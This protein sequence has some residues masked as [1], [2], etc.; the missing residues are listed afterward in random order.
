MSG[1]AI[2]TERQLLNAKLTD[3]A[4]TVKECENAIWD[5]WCEWMDLTNTVTVDY[6]HHYDTRDPQLEQEVIGKSLE[7]ITSPTYVDWAQ[8]ELVKL[9]VRDEEQMNLILAAMESEPTDINKT[10]DAETP[11]ADS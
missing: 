9:I 1:V 3:L 8:K 11:S 10:D 2:A 7:I 6:S 5:L 4:D